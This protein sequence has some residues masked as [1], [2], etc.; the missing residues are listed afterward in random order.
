MTPE[1]TSAVAALIAI[2]IGFFSTLYATRRQIDASLVSTS[3]QRWIDSLR[4]SVAEFLAVT[5]QLRY[6]VTTAAPGEW[7][8][9]PGYEKAIFLRAN[10]ALLSNPTEAD[11][12]HL[13]ILLDEMLSYCATFQDSAAQRRGAELQIEITS[14]CQ[15]ILKREWERVK[16]GEP[17]LRWK[18]KRSVAALH[19]SPLS[20]SEHALLGGTEA[21]F[22]PSS[23][24]EAQS[25]RRED[26]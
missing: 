10:I 16:A 7:H 2:G 13:V 24:D 4:D 5:A 17:L 18:G 15:A 8:K 23:A 3:R 12:R 6:T 22:A 9:A 20:A 14:Q 25:P 26:L 19:T 1:W 21:R 11:H